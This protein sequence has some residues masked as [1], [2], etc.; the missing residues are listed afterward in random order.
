MNNSGLSG[1]FA[2]GRR[3]LIDGCGRRVLASAGSV[4]S[5]TDGR[6]GST[7]R[8]TTTP[9]PHHSVFY[10]PDALPDAVGWAAGM[11]GYWRGYLSAARSRLG[12]V[13][14]FVFVNENCP[15]PDLVARWLATL[16]APGGWCKPLSRVL[17]DVALGGRRRELGGTASLGGPSVSDFSRCPG[18]LRA[19]IVTGP[20]VVCSW[21]DRSPFT[22]PSVSK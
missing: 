15:P 7:R 4:M 18:H 16:G 19:K 20:F 2:A 5:R 11:V 1:G 22:M 14:V 8:Q 13:S 6:G 12:F 10:G 9:A 21:R 3:R 17:R